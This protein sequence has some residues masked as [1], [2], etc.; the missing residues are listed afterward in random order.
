MQVRD[1]SVLRINGNT[2]KCAVHDI[3]IYIFFFSPCCILINEFSAGYAPAKN[4]FMFEKVFDRN[5]A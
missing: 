4:D 2:N 3:Y 5:S 1:G